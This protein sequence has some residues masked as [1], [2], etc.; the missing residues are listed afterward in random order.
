MRWTTRRHCHVDR[1]A[2]AWLI[3]R[4]LDPE[5]E[6]VFVDDPE[7]V[8]A[9]ATAA[10]PE[11]SGRRRRTLGRLRRELQR[12]RARDYFPPPERELAQR[13]VEELAALVEEPVG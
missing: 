13:A 12:I 2:C 4:F 7:E 6:F 10:L 9:D 5:A 1:A 8:P 11:R 3:R